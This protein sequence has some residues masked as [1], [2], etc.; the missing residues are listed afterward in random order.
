MF[1]TNP[2]QTGDVERG[3]KEPLLA[4]EPKDGTLTATVGDHDEPLSALNYFLFMLFGMGTSWTMSDA[5]WLQIPYFQRFQPEKAN[6]AVHFSI[7]V[8]VVIFLFI[9]LYIYVEPKLN[10]LWFM[11][12]ILALSFICCIMSTWWWNI[13]VADIS[14]VLYIAVFISAVVGQVFNILIL[15]YCTKI[16]NYTTG[17]LSAG[18]TAGEV[19]LYPEL[20]S[21][22]C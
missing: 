21:A 11:R 1:D 15:P 14:I 18:F 6:L 19:Y 17:P 16:N 5:L 13:V 20:K 10:Y 3:P 12:G 9:P 7:C 4:N 2:T 8:S 22:K